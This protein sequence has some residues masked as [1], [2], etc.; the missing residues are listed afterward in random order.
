MRDTAENGEPL[1]PALQE[2]FD[3]QPL[4]E[5]SR[6][7]S[8]YRKRYSKDDKQSVYDGVNTL[9]PAEQLDKEQKLKSYI[10]RGYP[11]G[12]NFDRPMDGKGVE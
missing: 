3:P 1:F 4:W 7:P 9:S 5:V 8:M 11:F 2:R 10:E 12:G 6:K